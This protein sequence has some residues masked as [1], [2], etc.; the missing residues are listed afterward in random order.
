MNKRE[1]QLSPEFRRQTAKVILAIA[2]FLL[3]YLLIL[4]LV[5]G[6]TALCVAAAVFLVIVK[7][8]FIT[9][10]I[11]FGLASLGILILIFLLKFMFKSH[12][13]E[14]SH[15]TEITDADEPELF[16][17]IDEIVREVGTSH[18]KRVYL[19]ADVNAAVFYDS[20]F[21]S[22]LFPIKKNL[23]IGLG[24]VNT[25]TREE[26][27]AILSH[28]FGHFS[29][30]TMKL[31]SYVYNV[32]QV[33][34]NMLYDNESYGKLVHGWSNVNG[35]VTFFVAVAVEIVKSIQWMLRQ[36]Y[37]IVNKRYMG[38][39]REM[40]FHADEIAASVTGYEPLKSSLLR[41][42]LAD[43]SYTN[44]LNFY[45]EKIAVNVKSEN[46]YKDQTVV[47]HLLAE[48]NNLPLKNDLPEIT[49]KSQSKFDK[50]KLVIKDQWASHPSVEDR[51]ERLERTGFSVQHPSG[52]L[53]NTVFRNIEETQKMVTGKLFEAVNYE[54]DVRFISSEEFRQELRQEALSGRFASMYNGYYDHKNPAAIDLTPNPSAVVP[55]N[56]PELFADDKVDMVYTCFGLHNDIET[57]K[58]IS[59]N[60]GT[61][62][63]FDYDGIRYELDDTDELVD[64]LTEEWNEMNGLILKHDAD[65]FEYFRRLEESLNRPKQLERL[66]SAY[67]EYDTL[68]SPRYAIYTQLVNELGFIQMTT[69]NAQ[70]WDNLENA[71]P[72]E[73]K[74]KEEI[75]LMMKEPEFQTELTDDHRMKLERYT[76]NT[77]VY[78][79]GTYYYEENLGILFS[80]I[81]TYAGLLTNVLLLKKNGILAYQEELT[82]SN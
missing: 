54:G 79:S 59:N 51:I 6:L 14:R 69:P 36:L 21:W 67:F 76:S 80:G 24:L 20:S 56:T 52:T 77:W 34:F 81:N 43:S 15:L 78:F 61:L 17:M 65:I 48:L 74:V 1:I 26:L 9:L 55:V 12:K 75:R 45:N 44:V 50:S 47:M 16:T 3:T 35:I 4:L 40:E 72:T 37:E 23:M 73:D 33:I 10:A 7:P 58:H 62:K 31:G 38:L 49:Q 32:N 63:T 57:L 53:A 41:M 66:Y 42:T 30:R 5:V 19:S 29:Q 82:N 68:F 71:R 39:S 22:M 25:V 2:L 28:E 60:P 13:V 46:I 8:M 27:K 64:K 70:I 18:P 11:G